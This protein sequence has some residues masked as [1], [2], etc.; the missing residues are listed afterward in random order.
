[1]G[2]DSWHCVYTSTSHEGPCSPL[3]SLLKTLSVNVRHVWAGAHEVTEG[4]G[5]EAVFTAEPSRQ[6]FL[7]I[8]KNMHTYATTLLYVCVY[9]V[10]FLISRSS[11]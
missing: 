11:S 1:M 6:P 5:A 7:S 3:Q 10:P 8:C 4:P 9:L 2:G